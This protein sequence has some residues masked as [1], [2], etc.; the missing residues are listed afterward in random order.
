MLGL[1]QPHLRR[2][3]IQSVDRAAHTSAT[4]SRPARPPASHDDRRIIICIIYV[5]PRTSYEHVTCHEG[6]C[7]C[8]RACVGVWVCPT[9][10]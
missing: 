9:Y 5:V 1:K 4:V 7:A 10:R 6:V 2:G 8:V 3:L